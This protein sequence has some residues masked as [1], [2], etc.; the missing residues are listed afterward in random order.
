M[1]FPWMLLEK[2]HDRASATKY[3]MKARLIYWHKAHLQKR[4]V[5]EMKIQEV[6][7]STKYEDG[8]RYSMILIDLVSKR[9]VLMDNHHPKGP[10]IHLDEREL[11]YTFININ[12]LIEDFKKLVFEHLE[13]KI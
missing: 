8:A 4:Y 9:R 6:E 13:V 2:N 10:H 1:V 5:L 7:K 12:C 11:P 3:T